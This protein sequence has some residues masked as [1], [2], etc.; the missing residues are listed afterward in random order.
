MIWHNNLVNKMPELYCKVTA[1][2]RRKDNPDAEPVIMVSTW[3]VKTESNLPS[4]TDIYVGMKDNSSANFH[5]FPKGEIVGL[6]NLDWT[7][8]QPT[9]NQSAYDRVVHPNLSY[10]NGQAPRNLFGNDTVIYVRNKIVFGPGTTFPTDKNIIFVAGEGVDINPDVN[11]P[12][13]VTIKVGL[14]HFPGLA[15]SNSP[16]VPQMSSSLVTSFCN[17]PLKYRHVMKI[18][19][20]T[21]LA[22]AEPQAPARSWDSQ[23]SWDVYPNPSDEWVYL[24][25]SI[26]PE[27]RTPALLTLR[28]ITG[29]PIHT[30]EFQADEQ[31][32]Y[33]FNMDEYPAGVYIFELN[34]SDKP[35]QSFKIV[36]P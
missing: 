1:T 34:Q 15:C 30:G 5:T 3:K 25:P 35:A 4:P 12:S 8:A 16:I 20:K 32:R 22:D 26:K 18:A 13:N 7:P 10:S 21:D 28:D 19:N 33:P 17:D 6:V 11:I 24:T 31:G 23:T 29:R 2:F 27:T 9:I 36:R 14:E